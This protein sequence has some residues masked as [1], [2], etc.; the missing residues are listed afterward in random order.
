MRSLPSPLLL[1]LLAC[2]SIAGGQEPTYDPERTR[3]VLT[4]LIE[5]KLDAGVASISIALVRGDEIAWTAAFGHANVRMEVPATP[6]TIYVT[7]STFKA[8]TATALLQ[9][10]ERGLVELDDP[11]NEH[12]GEHRVE[13]LE[14]HPV[15]LRHILSHTSE[16]TPGANT[17][18][19]WSRTLPMRLDELP[20][21]VRA[22]RPP[23][24]KYEYNNY[25]Q[26]AVEATEATG[27]DAAR[28][29][30][31]QLAL[32]V[33][34]QAGA[35]RVGL[36]IPGGQED[37]DSGGAHRRTPRQVREESTPRSGAGPGKNSGLLG[38]PTQPHRSPGIENT[39]G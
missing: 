18:E 33:E 3:R 2:H 28:E 14:D 11:I 31:A 6:E 4:E 39:T 9:L 17:K 35:G 13:D 34:R 30:A 10:A 26:G 1:V 16:L 32:D 37:G 25:G 27:Q 15:T 36:S 22:V 19:V 7:G 5:R 38:E 20:G 29:L 12:L 21:A 24:E 23:E 8:V